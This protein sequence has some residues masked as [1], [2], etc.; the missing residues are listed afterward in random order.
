[1]TACPIHPETLMQWSEAWSR[2]GFETEGDFLW[3]S[4]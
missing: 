2:G 3:S 4:G 1:M